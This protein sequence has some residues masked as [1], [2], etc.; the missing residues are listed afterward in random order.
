MINDMTCCR[1]IVRLD[2]ER[3]LIIT[4]PLIHPFMKLRHLYC[5]MSYLAWAIFKGLVFKLA[6]EMSKS[7]VQEINSRAFPFLHS[8]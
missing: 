3:V 8:Q 4:Y 7:S 1:L 2:F 5:P 6:G